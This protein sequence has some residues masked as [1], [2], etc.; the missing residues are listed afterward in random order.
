MQCTQSCVQNASMR[1]VYYYDEITTAII[2]N[3]IQYTNC[4]FYDAPVT[5][6]LVN[7]E[8]LWMCLATCYGDLLF[9]WVIFVHYTQSVDAQGIG[10]I[11][12]VG[13]WPWLIIKSVVVL[14]FMP[15]YA[16]VIYFA[17][18]YYFIDGFW[19]YYMWDSG[20]TW[21]EPGEWPASPAYF[22]HDH[23]SAVWV[24]FHKPDHI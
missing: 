11:A 9:Y 18:M 8:Q 7:S 10:L 21:S 5:H 14:T 12:D 6:Y 1:D 20:W 4:D 19:G 23:G 16:L 13:R 15:I 2:E 24:S 22:C 17:F 3:H